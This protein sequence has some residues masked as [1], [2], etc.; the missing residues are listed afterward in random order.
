MPSTTTANGWQA[1]QSSSAPLAG[2][3]KN[4]GGGTA[5]STASETT[6]NRTSVP[7]Q[8]FTPGKVNRTV[9]GA[10]PT[11]A[12]KPPASSIQGTTAAPQSKLFDT[13]S[14][15]GTT[16]V[17]QSR[18]FATP[19]ASF[20]GAGASGAG[21]GIQS[22][23]GLESF[24][25]TKSLTGGVNLANGNLVLRNQAMAYNA[26]G[27]S[28]NLDTFFNTLNTAQGSLGYGGSLSTGQD[29]GLQVGTSTTTF[30]GPSGFT[31]AFTA[32][33]S[34][35]WT[36][37][38]GVN[39]DL[40]HNSDGTW[41]M[42]YHAS[43]EKLTF[44]AG[45]YLIKD[46]DRNGVG[47]T[48]SYDSSNR[49]TSLTDANGQVTTFTYSTLGLTKMTDPVG[50]S[51]SIAYNSGGGVRTITDASGAVTTIDN[52][53]TGSLDGIQTPDGNW[54]YFTY[55]GAQR[56][57]AVTRYLTPGATS[58]NAAVTSFAYNTTS[59]ASTSTKETS[60]TGGVSTF[61]LDSSGRVTS[62]TDPLGR[63]RS[64]TWTPNS[65][66]ATA[67]DAAGS[68]GTGTGTGGTGSTA[69]NITSYSYDSM[70][71]RTAVQLPTGAATRTSYTATTGS[72]GTAYQPKTAKDAA[73][74]TS[75][76]A[77]DNVGNILSV[78]D[79]TATGSGG[80][81]ATTSTFT[82]QAATASATTSPTQCAAKTGQICT[83]TD[84]NGNATTYRYDSLG[85]LTKV[86]PAAP[87]GATTY[88][89]DSAN[90][91]ASVTDGKGQ[92]TQYVYDAEDRVTKT[93]FASG[94]TVTNTY[95]ADGNLT[96]SVDSAAGTSTFSY[97][98]LDREVSRQQPNM[99]G[100]SFATGYDKAGN[101]TSVED[102]YGQVT[103]AYDAANQL[104]SMTEPDGSS[105]DTIT[106]AYDRNGAETSRTFPGGLIQT[107][108]RDAS[109][110]PT[111]ITDAAGSFV[112]S[113]LGYSYT[114]PGTS[115]ASGDRALVQ[116]RTDY[117]GTTAPAGSVT[118]Y[119]HDGLNRL[120]KATEKTSTGAANAS[121]A[122][123]YDKA[124][125]RT[126]VTT[127]GDTTTGATAS[128]A[129][130][131]TVWGYNGAN[132]AVSRGGSTSGW[133]YDAN[134][135][136][137]AA[138][139]WGSGS[140]DARDALASATP[141]GSSS[142]VAYS[143][144]GAGNGARQSVDGVKT[145]NGPLGLQATFDTD[146][147]GTAFRYTPD[148]RLISA[149]LPDGT[150]RYYTTDNLGNVTAVATDS[151]ITAQYSYDPYGTLRASTGP[152]AGGNPMRYGQGY[153]DTAT[154][155]TKLGI[156]YY[157]PAQGRFTQQ[158][159]TGQDPHYMYA[160]GCPST[161]NDPTGAKLTGDCV[162]SALALTGS[163]ILFGL[164]IGA[165]IPT[166]GASTAA[167]VGTGLLVADTGHSYY[168][169]CY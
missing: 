56:V 92:K 128:T 140:Y 68:T 147:S 93:T 35:G 41:S 111:R 152:E 50:R 39:A 94:A 31:A 62:T 145:I 112:V 166:L 156:R 124:G 82:Y 96:Q 134:G 52:S 136:Q 9:V 46:V 47:L 48:L 36:S 26:P 99:S 17:S 144:L 67:T 69:G 33:S 158:D 76:F 51:V 73:G 89:Y 4:A 115:G 58:G 63:K 146:N 149:G 168:K 139:T 8:A 29:I 34:G 103:Y 150:N 164:S 5:P 20:P 65:D 161:Y 49:L 87:L 167:S 125:N 143:Y 118:T 53:R 123:T 6:S 91:L 59:G 119:N 88:T 137:T 24:S 160:K 25:L 122:Y 157:D 32:N 78:K 60:P 105:T 28:V 11:T 100:N 61:A 104:T 169:N 130:V 120:T 16:A 110:R 74:N 117:A 129:S 113:D 153:T 98:A 109:G 70:N 64:Q 44:T 77:Y 2:N 95:D 57:T 30:Y 42:T 155:L 23:Y 135:N 22:Y 3:W 107:T 108:T 151:A 1:A 7:P 148:G 10:T 66:L 43:S 15:Q 116:S 75:A 19:S 162:S 37:P 21:L 72:T 165:E 163:T 12:W 138:A 106:F 18:L 84:G 71:N 101:I 126:G 142:A 131:S 81:G 54:T 14:T 13:P 133:S 102:I 121:W 127:A 159:P 85:N 38:A 40:V 154:G 83:S 141:T 86:T 80:T 114:A 132:E 27:L 55:D 97:D 79:T 90:R 45:G